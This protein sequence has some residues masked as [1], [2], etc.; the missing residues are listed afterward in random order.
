AQIYKSN[1]ALFQFNPKPLTNLLQ[2]T[3][4]V[5]KLKRQQYSNLRNHHK[6]ASMINKSSLGAR[7]MK[8]T[9]S[10]FQSKVFTREYRRQTKRERWSS[11][12]YYMLNVK[13]LWYRRFKSHAYNFC[14]FFLFFS[15]YQ[16]G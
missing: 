9:R 7:K 13:H 4:N 15:N 1:V 11:S 14:L 3:R 6:E 8:R 5:F 10:S 12:R 2:K 16:R